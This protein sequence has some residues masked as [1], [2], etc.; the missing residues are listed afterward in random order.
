MNKITN[1]QRAHELAIAF[2]VQ[3]NQQPKALHELGETYSGAYLELLTYFDL[4]HKDGLA[5]SLAEVDED[6]KKNLLDALNVDF[7]W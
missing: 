2:A 4:M 3:M 6:T 5:D 1:A 7:H